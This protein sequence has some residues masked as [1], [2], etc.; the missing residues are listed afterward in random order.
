MNF[1]NFNLVFKSNS[2]FKGCFQYC[3]ECYRKTAL[4]RLSIMNS[5]VLHIEQNYLKSPANLLAVVQLDIDSLD[6]N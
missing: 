3:P 5:A 2:V 1:K 4:N 6:Q